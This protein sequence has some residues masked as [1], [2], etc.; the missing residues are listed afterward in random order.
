MSHVQVVLKGTSDIPEEV[1]GQVD[2]VLGIV[3]PPLPPA[4]E[5]K[6]RQ[7]SSDQFEV[8]LCD[9]LAGGV[10]VIAILTRGAALPVCLDHASVPAGSPPVAA[11]ELRHDRWGKDVEAVAG[12]A[13]QLLADLAANP[14]Q[15]REVQSRRAA[16][17]SLAASLER[18]R[19]RYIPHDRAWRLV[20]RAAVVLSAVLL[21]A[22]AFAAYSWHASAP[23]RQ[24]ESSALRLAEAGG[25]DD[26][27][28]A[29]SDL[30]RIAA[31][32]KD[33]GVE[34]LAVQRLKKILLDKSSRRDNRKQ[35]RLLALTG[36]LT[37]RGTDITRDF[38]AE[39]L[40]NAD[41]G[42]APLAGVIL[43]GVSLKGARLAGAVLDRADL[44]GSDLSAAYIAHA[45][46]HEAKFTGADFTELD[47]FNA[48]GFTEPQLASVVRATLEPCP[49][50]QAGVHSVKAFE[51][52]FDDEYNG[53]YHTLSRS[54]QDWL[55]SVWTRYRAN[56][57]MCDIV[58]RLLTGRDI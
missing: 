28:R 30:Q 3:G 58:D 7:G 6:E 5:S 39:G 16:D 49:T 21:V 34:N 46:V 42:E 54:L 15:A 31:S 35:I 11:V 38:L 37:I 56:G 4:P 22:I 27:K 50:D 52:R 41:L 19:R 14:R 24:I 51:L 48:R 53:D 45:S 17:A 44:S 40:Q 47:W 18:L 20:V 13:E 9:A 1:S 57:G 10:P 2:L 23:V 8:L 26:A 32:S 25:V 12:A 43:R 55:S 33:P 36:I 29:L